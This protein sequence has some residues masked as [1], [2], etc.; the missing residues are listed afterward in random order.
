MAL[1]NIQRACAVAALLLVGTHPA[2]AQFDLTG[3]GYVQYGDAQSYSL[4][5]LALQDGCTTPGCDFYVVSTPGAIKGLTV[6]GTGSGGQ[7]VLTNFSGMDN[8]YSTPNGPPGGPSTVPYWQPSPLT[9][10]G[11]TGTVNNNDPNAWDSSLLA[12]K[13]YL[14]GES[15]IF[16][17]NN[18]QVNNL[19]TSGQSLAAWAQVTVKNAAGTVIGT[20]DLVNKSATAQ[21]GGAYVTVGEGGGGALLG[22]VGNYT[23]QAGYTDPVAGTAA[24]T[25]YVLSGGQ[26]CLDAGGNLVSCSSPSVVAGPINHNLGA[27]QAVYAIVFPELNT[28]LA[29]LFGLSDAVLSQYT[30]SVDVRLGCDPLLDP[31]AVVCTGDQNNP[32]L[33]GRNLNNGFEQIFISKATDVVNIPEP[34]T[35]L[36]VGLTLLG[37]GAARRRR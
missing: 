35:V 32:L 13:S 15:M 33:Y 21:P 31:N 9:S 10:N 23:S 27:N 18:N 30:L 20:Y 29:G 16:F 8:A 36:L 11:T 28:Q 3:A 7:D 4:P 14:A 6:L 24:S 1:R 19:G 5:V 17:F 22:N 2:L 26:L 37:L 34:G 25:D 12:L